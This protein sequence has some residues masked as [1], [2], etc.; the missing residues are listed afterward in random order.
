MSFLSPLNPR[1]TIDPHVPV[2]TRS[3]SETK[4][5]AVAANLAA[6]RDGRA[7]FYAQSEFNSTITMAQ[8]F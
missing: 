4:S 8:N 5:H 3:H 2:H 7:V 1:G 6:S